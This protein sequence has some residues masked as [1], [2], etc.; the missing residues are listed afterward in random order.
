MEKRIW[1][2][3]MRLLAGG[4]AAALLFAG[5]FSG[6][7]LRRLLPAGG[8]AVRV[9]SV[10]GLR[11]KKWSDAVSL[12]SMVEAGSM[13]AYY[14]DSRKPAVELYVTEG[15]RVEA[16]TPL[17]RYDC[18]VLVEE[19][20]GVEQSLDEPADLFGEA[21]KLYRNLEGDKARSRQHGECAGQGRQRTGFR[22]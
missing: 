19:L 2:K 16:G 15:Q 14:Y 8:E 12:P 7:G 6:M 20:S 10:E 17:L 3:K 1:T 22:H 9:Y 13:T 5:F 11:D 4:C 21:G 18:S